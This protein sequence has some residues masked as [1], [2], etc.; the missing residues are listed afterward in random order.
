MQPILVE[1]LVAVGS[2][3]VVSGATEGFDVGYNYSPYRLEEGGPGIV[4]T[5]IYE[6]P[7]G[8]TLDASGLVVGPSQGGSC[9]GLA[10]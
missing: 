7:C 1:S 8:G 6:N 3:I 5:R 10:F 9:H 2:L 4:A